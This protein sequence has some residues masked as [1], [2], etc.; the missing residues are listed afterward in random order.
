[1]SPPKRNNK[2]I[3]KLV[4]KKKAASARRPMT[5][6]K[7]PSALNN[8]A[9]GAGTFLG[10]TLGGPMLG[11]LAGDASSWITKIMGGGDYSI[12]NNS[13]LC[14]DNIPSFSSNGDNV[15]VKHREFIGDLSS[16]ITWVNN[17]YLINPGNNK[18]FPWLSQLAVLFEEY[19]FLGLIFEYKTTSASALNST[20]TALG[21]MIYATD[22]DAID[23]PFTDKR[24]AENSEYVTTAA[25]C[26]SFIHAVE[27]AKNNN[28][29]N[30][31]YVTTINNLINIPSGQDPR[32]Y[33][34]G[35]FQQ[36]SVGSQA[37]ATTGE[38][39][40]SYQCRFSKPILSLQ[41]LPIPYYSSLFYNA[42][43]SATSQVS[44]VNLNVVQQYGGTTTA[45][46][47]LLLTLDPVTFGAYPVWDIIIQQT[48]GV[49]GIAPVTFTGGAGG[50][51][52]TPNPVIASTNLNF[53]SIPNGNG[54]NVIPE[55]FLAFSDTATTSGM[56]GTQNF[57]IQYYKIQFTNALLPATIL[58][59][60]FGWSGITAANYLMIHPGVYV[61]GLQQKLNADGTV[62]TPDP[63]NSSS[64]SS[65]A[66]MAWNSVM[67]SSI[68]KSTAK[69]QWRGTPLESVVQKP[70]KPNRESLKALNDT[71]N[72]CS[73]ADREMSIK[74]SLTI[75]DDD[76][77]LLCT[78]QCRSETAD[79]SNVI[80]C[81]VRCDKCTGKPQ[82]EH[83]LSCMDVTSVIRFI[84]SWDGPGKLQFLD[85]LEAYYDLSTTEKS[86]DRTL[87]VSVAIAALN[88]A[89]T[90][91]YREDQL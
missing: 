57:T 77:Q 48:A 28:I 38:L 55:T 64:S 22:Y 27:C 53:F 41:G 24:H 49:T 87:N 33:Y 84:R 89:E 16:S 80:K 5:I 50:G 45:N 18:L 54:L 15:I 43:T 47:T 40:A 66:S 32:L 58:L 91:Q 82:F 74:G 26:Q 69:E 37:V 72:K 71:L 19:E 88:E 44:Q 85:Q 9:R 65:S 36:C 4:V 67:G 79:Y 17:G 29:F 31:Q 70:A 86:D 61:A 11:K 14:G 1:M 20:N 3:V 25:P 23:L 35:N 8:L 34:L 46:N 56:P 39:W 12:K 76:F 60:T 68:S 90:K 78:P 42:S 52:N 62:L 59:P 83:F 63:L 73:N 10:T 81:C 13:L 21:T 51:Y 6:A 75:S 30:K 2:K 7:E